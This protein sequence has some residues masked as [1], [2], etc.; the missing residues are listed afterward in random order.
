MTHV[1][2]PAHDSH[3]YHSFIVSPMKYMSTIT[4]LLSVWCNV[5]NVFLCRL[6]GLVI[7]ISADAHSL[8]DQHEV[9]TRQSQYPTTLTQENPSNLKPVSND[10]TSA[11][12]LLCDTAV[13]FLH[14]FDLGTKV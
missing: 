2:D 6:G 9:Q 7:S 8:L 5:I 13:C 4:G 10:L 1:L 12:A 3:L 14:A 11:S